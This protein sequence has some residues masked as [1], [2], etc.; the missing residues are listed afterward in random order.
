MKILLINPPDDLEAL[1]GQGATFIS[2][3]EP[4]GLLYMAAFLQREG[5]DVEVVDAYAEHL[6]LD[7][8]KSRISQAPPDVVGLTS[9]TSNGAIV[10]ELGKWLKGNFPGM[11]VALGN[12]HGAVYA[13]QYLRNG[14]CDLVV[15]GEGEQAMLDLLR[16]CETGSRDFAAIA[17]A[18]SLNN[19]DFVPNREWGITPD[20]SKIPLPARDLVNQEL[21]NIPSISNLPYSGKGGK[22][23]HMFTSRGCPNRCTFCVVHHGRRQRFNSVDRVVDE[24]SLLVNKYGADYI[25]IM[26]SLFISDKRRVIDICQE[27]RNRKLDFKWGCEAHVRFIDEELVRVMESAGCYDMAFGIESG[28]QRLLDGVKKK[29]RLDQVQQAVETVKRFSGI[30]V[31]G[32]FILGLPGETYQDSLQ[33]IAFAKALPLDMAQ[34]SI[35]TPY[36]GSEIFYELREKGQVDTGIRPDGTLDTSVWLRYSAYISYTDNQPIWV[37]PELTADQLKKL[38]KK[39][40]RQFYWRPKQFLDQLK[41]VRIS[42][43]PAIIKAFV[44]TFF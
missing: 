25:F 40:V 19:G 24:M 38:Q 20:L 15:H 28:V 33:T 30:K 16:V 10:Y 4:L 6:S 27:I 17:C 31:S 22:G 1:L 35:L 13:E 21:Y 12:I 2:T 32:L 29:I 34:F 37:T 42:E 7:A 44:K 41:R 9:F 23:K 26:D 36:P 14:C 5:Y 11:V 3:F 18:S 39:A 43:L 8:L